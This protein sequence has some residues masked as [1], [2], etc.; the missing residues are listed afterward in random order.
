MGLVESAN[1]GSLKNEVHGKGVRWVSRATDA[2]K[3][4]IR[5]RSVGRD[6]SVLWVALETYWRRRCLS[7]GCTVTSARAFA[8]AVRPRR[9]DWLGGPRPELRAVSFVCPRYDCYDMPGCTH[10][11]AEKK[12]SR[13][14]AKSVAPLRTSYNAWSW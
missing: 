14:F 13:S 9:L 8:F 4:L 1:A 5:R 11:V 10:T 7:A 12:A 3:C 2:S 6:V